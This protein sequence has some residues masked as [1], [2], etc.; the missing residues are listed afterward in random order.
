MKTYEIQ[1]MKTSYA[2]IFVDAE[3]KD[4]A[5]ILAWKKI[6]LGTDINDSH[7]DILFIQEQA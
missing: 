5:Q 2:N 1:L 4:E 6:E 7:W 3:S